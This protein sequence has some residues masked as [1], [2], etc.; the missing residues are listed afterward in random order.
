MAAACTLKDIQDKSLLRAHQIIAGVPLTDKTV[1][2][3][4]DGFLF[5]GSNV[6]AYYK[7][8]AEKK[9]V[10]MK[11]ENALSRLDDWAERTFGEQYSTGWYTL[12]DNENANISK[13]YYN[14]K[15]LFPADLAQAYEYKFGNIA[16]IDREMVRNTRKI[17]MLSTEFYDEVN[18]DV[19][20]EE[21]QNYLYPEAHASLTGDFGKITASEIELSMDQDNAL[22]KDVMIQLVG[23]LSESM[24]VPFD[25]ITGKQAAELIGDRYNGQKAFFFNGRVYLIG[26]SFSSTMLFH[27]FAHPIVRTLLIDNPELFNTLYNNLI[28]SMPDLVQRVA[29]DKPGLDI[30]SDEFKE[31]VMTYALSEAA[32]TKYEGLKENTGF[33]AAIKEIMYRIKQLFRKIFNKSL[34]ISKL[35]VN[36]SLNDIADILVKADAITVNVESF[37]KD[38]I[39]RFTEEG[40]KEMADILKGDTMFDTM[41][42]TAQ[43]VFNLVNTSLGK[44]NA[45]DKDSPIHK[46]L[47]NEFS[48]SELKEMRSILRPSQNVQST[49][50]HLKTLAIN[51]KDNALLDKINEALEMDP[52]SKFRDLRLILELVEDYLTIDEVIEIKRDIQTY[53]ALLLSKLDILKQEVLFEQERAD[54]IIKN[55]VIMTNI[56]EKIKHEIPNLLKDINNKEKLREV[57]NYETLLSYWKKE[58]EKVKTDLLNSGVPSSN[59][60]ISKINN[61]LDN[62]EQ[63]LK[64]TRK[65]AKVGVSLVLAEQLEYLQEGIDSYYT[66]ALAHLKAKN[67]DPAQIKRLEEEYEATTLKKKDEYGNEMSIPQV[68]TKLLEGELGD[69]NWANSFFEG[70]MYNQDPVI[71]SFAKYVKDNYTDVVSV[72]QKNITDFHKKMNPLLKA[73]GWNPNNVAALGKE[74]T[75]IDDIGYFDNAGVFHKRKVHSF[76]NPNKYWRSDLKEKQAALQRAKDKYVASGKESDKTIYYNLQTEFDNWKT[77]YFYRPYVDEVY[78]LDKIFN[79][80]PGDEI[81]NIAKE[82]RDAALMDIKSK[83]NPKSPEQYKEYNEALKRYSALSILTNFDGSAKTDS[84]LEIAERIIEYN[85]TSA[86]YYEWV[87]RPNAFETGYLKELQ[88]NTDIVTKQMEAEHYDLRDPGKQLILQHRVEKLMKGWLE[89]NSTVSLTQKFWDDRNELY[90][91]IAEIEDMIQQTPEYIEKERSLNGRRNHILLR[92]KDSNGQIDTTLLS[93]EE[94]VELGKIEDELKE[95][96]NTERIGIDKAMSAEQYNQFKQ[97]QKDIDKEINDLYKLKNKAFKLRDK[98]EMAALEQSIIA[99]KQKKQELLAEMQEIQAEFID[100]ELREKYIELKEQLDSMVQYEPTEYYYDSFEEAF[101]NIEDDEIKADFLAVLGITSISSIRSMDPE[102]RNKMLNHDTMRILFRDEAFEKWFNIAHASNEWDNY[103]TG[104]IEISYYPRQFYSYM[105]PTDVN[106]YEKT[107]VNIHGVPTTIGRVP[108]RKYKERRVRDFYINEKGERV[109]LRT[110]VIVGGENATKNNTGQW[111]PRNKKDMQAYYEANKEDFTD[112]N[113]NV[114]DY[115][116]YINEDYYRLKDNNPNMFAVLK[117]LT[118]EHLTNQ[119]GALDKDKLYMDVPRFEKQW[120]ETFQS[121]S[122]KENVSNNPLSILIRKIRDFFVKVKYAYLQGN[123]YS[124]DQLDEAKLVTLDL[125]DS[126]ISKIVMQGV[127]Y[128]EENLVSLDVMTSMMQY[129]QAVE[130]QKKLVEMLPVAKNL[131]SAFLDI[132]GKPTG[133]KDTTKQDAKTWY[134]RLLIGLEKVKPKFFTTKQESYRS[135]TIEAIINRE[136]YGQLQTGFSKD[137]QGL[138]KFSQ[139][140]MGRASFGYFAF[141][142]PSA[143]KN[144]LGQ[145]YQ[146]MLYTIGGTEYNAKDLIFGEAYG[147]KLSTSISFNIYNK[148]DLPLPLQLADIMDPSQGRTLD[149][150]HK[151]LTRTFTKDMTSAGIFYNTR[152]WLQL[153]ATMTVFGAHL[154]NKVLK[155]YNADGSYKTIKYHEAWEL[156]NGQIQLKSGIDPEWGH[157]KSVYVKQDG[158]TFDQVAYRYGLTPEELEKKISKDEFKN[159]AIDGQLTI[160][161]SKKFKRFVRT[162]HDLQNKLNGAYAAWEQPEAN[163][164]LLF[165]LV[166]YLRKYFTRMF[167]YRFQHKGKFWKPQARYNIATESLEMGW[168]MEVVKAMFE[169]VITKGKSLKTLGKKEKMAALRLMIEV[170]SLMML[171]FYLPLILGFDP[172]DDEKYAKMRERSGSMPF[173]FAPEDEEHPFELG[174]WLQNHAILMS[175]QV[176]QENETFIPFPG[177]GLDDYK[178]MASLKSISFG[179]T[180]DAYAKIGQTIYDA[181]A[182]KKSAYYKRETGPYDWQQEGSFKGFKHLAAMAGL[183]GSTIAPEVATRTLVSWRSRT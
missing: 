144:N 173:L 32:S 45:F 87:E 17:E 70:Y 159:L 152:Q 44:M 148:G 142:I 114:E 146:S 21:I 101:S 155:Q 51:N 97:A 53:E 43:K 117:A 160:G 36:T 172:D 127:N 110:E 157:T 16:P 33:L 145:Q 35:S 168:Y 163:R 61:I 91:Q 132:E 120:L 94:M 69:A 86:K 49:L 99:A 156:V 104:D 7:N 98:K 143:I 176:R 178:N 109:N 80:Y 88:K 134:K 76:L 125:M 170:T 31:E 19:S 183:T 107:I 78:Q 92:K 136:F 57:T 48:E 82:R 24:G 116:Q 105:L 180:I 169:M 122:T 66:K 141:N 59:P 2:G 182:Q 179:P 73:A 58:W 26:D 100:P 4:H 93:E 103:Q 28:S 96:K 9:V 68:L 84:E 79:K 27:E 115:M 162:H 14:I 50:K 11:V 118:E 139:L 77:K 38:E 85:K 175:L 106:H 123:N 121:R 171:G 177:F 119:E 147:T 113:G 10:K 167:M 1:H 55:M 23:K 130:K 151:R 164:Y 89:E 64:E 90:R 81:G 67:A 13:S 112:I 74:V 54:A 102:P 108:S 15:L 52:I 25:F 165:R 181:I 95:L 62:V 18:E 12:E 161:T 135:K 153:Q 111:L 65:L 83:E 166:S 158:D 149:K 40:K 124:N 140:L 138:N 60:V 41:T 29:R 75:F 128:M 22:A 34:D 154:N 56:T 133:I 3:R 71:M 129:M 20:I 174:G 126:E 46:L 8:L 37:S 30:T 42:E 39:L 5:V 6:K 150:M 63:G 47:I 137:M 72:V 131:Q